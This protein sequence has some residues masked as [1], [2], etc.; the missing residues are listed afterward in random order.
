MCIFVSVNRAVQCGM[1]GI[2]NCCWTACWRDRT[3]WPSVAD[4]GVSQFSCLYSSILGNI[5]LISLGALLSLL[6]Q[7]YMM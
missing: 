5:E 3:C 4:G 2:G 1:E 7:Y 6:A